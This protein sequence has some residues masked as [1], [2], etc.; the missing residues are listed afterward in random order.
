MKK[1]QSLSL[2]VIIIAALAL[3]V[4]IVLGLIFTGKIKIFGTETRNC[5]NMGGSCKTTCGAN[6]ATFQNTN[7]VNLCCVEL[8]SNPTG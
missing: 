5:G 8:Y 6:E 3:L 1:A 2:N 7:C 4:L